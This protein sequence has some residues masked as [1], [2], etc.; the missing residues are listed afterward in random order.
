MKSCDRPPHDGTQPGGLL[1]PWCHT[2]LTGGAPPG[3]A[4]NSYVTVIVAGDSSLC[5]GPIGEVASIVSGCL[6]SSTVYGTSLSWLPRSLIVPLPK[7]HHRYQRG[8]GKYVSWKG[9]SGAGPSQRSKCMFAGTGI[10]SLNRSTI[11]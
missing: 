7:S 8:P 3:D 1:S 11:C 4:G 9:R 10:T 6:M 2:S 5:A